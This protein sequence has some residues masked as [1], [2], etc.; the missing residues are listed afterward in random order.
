MV[1]RAKKRKWVDLVA[2]LLVGAAAQ[3]LALWAGPDTSLV[4]M[5]LSADREEVVVAQLGGGSARA[6]QALS[7]AIDA[8]RQGDFDKAATLFREAQARAND[9][10]PDEQQEL[11]RLLAANTRA[12]K[13]R[14]EAR[15]QLDLAETALRQ[16]RAADAAALAKKASANE[17][18]LNSADKQRFQTLCQK[19]HV[20]PGKP[21]GAPVDNAAAQARGKLQQARAEM[22]HSNLDAA[23]ALAHEVDQ[24]HVQFGPR[25]DSPRRILEDLKLFHKD[26]KVM[27]LASRAA[28]QRGELDR[29]EQYAHEA[30]K[31]ASTF[32]F[33]FFGD[34]PSKA[35]KEIQAAR[36]SDKKQDKGAGQPSDKKSETASRPPIPSPAAQ[37][38]S[39]EKARLL[40]RQGRQAL[41][42]HDLVQ[43]RK[44]A[45]QAAALKPNLHWS[46]DN[47]AKLLEAI[48]HAESGH[49]GKPD[50]PANAAAIHNKDEALALLHKGREQLAKGDVEEAS[51]TA[52]RLKAA[53]HIHW[54]LF[55]EDTPDKLQADVKRASDQQNKDKSVELLAQARRLFEKKD[56]DAAQRL[57]YDAQKLH[58]PYSVWDLGDRP[59]KV[60]ADIQARRQQERPL[61]LPDPPV[62]AKDSADLKHGPLSQQR[63]GD[64]AVAQAN[65]TQPA[66]GEPTDRR[67]ETATGTT[68]NAQPASNT[69]PASTPTSAGDKLANQAK[70]GQL[71]VEAHTLLRQNRLVEA[72]DKID[73]ARRLGV[74][75][76]PDEENPNQLA[77]QTAFLARQRID[78]LVHHAGEILR[79][80]TQAPA[81]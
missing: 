22:A 77:Q 21:G 18:Y 72:R 11:A 8:Q 1:A 10:K 57:A 60:L 35:L 71:M 30:D 39:T 53:Q 70:A 52:A 3:P 81:V 12:L 7:A 66:K 40:V 58:G 47:P 45:E 23:E 6:R 43:A 69:R 31:L 27:L 15:G 9:L 44:C 37:G 74:V 28:L 16:G 42:G 63:P 29:A 55:F 26:P 14:Q 79:Y 73:E 34:S 76:R 25:E 46:E 41:A 50:A 65:A 67:P 49:A 64:Q 4:A 61:K 62:V 20:S 2:G 75:F 51:K 32:T 19:L 24:L 13:A 80:G 68:P 5:P 56:Y 78:S 36:G 54:G 59:D 48:G 38:E 33:A 17:L